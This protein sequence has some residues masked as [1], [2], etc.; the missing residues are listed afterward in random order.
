MQS[1]PHQMQDFTCQLGTVMMTQWMYQML[2]QT[3]MPNQDNV[4]L[5]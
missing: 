2:N 4:I 3:M 5:Y 1:F